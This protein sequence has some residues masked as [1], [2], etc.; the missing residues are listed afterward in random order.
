MGCQGSKTTSIKPCAAAALQS[1]I[2][3]STTPSEAQPYVLCSVYDGDTI[4]VRLPSS[5]PG[6]GQ[7]IRVRLLGIDT[8]ELKEKEPFAQEAKDHIVSLLSGSTGPTGRGDVGTT[9]YIA[10]P[11]SGDTTDKYGRLLGVLY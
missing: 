9:V 1:P 7:E 10:P 2:G 8:P 6:R 3:S 4:R 11:A 5:A